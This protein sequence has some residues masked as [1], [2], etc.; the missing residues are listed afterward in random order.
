VNLRC[1]DNPLEGGDEHNGE[2]DREEGGEEDGE[3]AREE[4][5]RAPKSA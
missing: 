1:H 3:E 2:E 5:V 4:A